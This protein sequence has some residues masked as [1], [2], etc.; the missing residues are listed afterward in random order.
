MTTFTTRLSAG[1]VIAAA[2]GAA[3]VARYST[4]QTAAADGWSA[5]NYDQSANRYSPLTQ[6][7]PANVSTLE[8]AWSVHLKP[9]GYA[10]KL[11]TDEAI[12]L[13][14]GNTMYSGSPYGAVIAVDATSG[15]EKWKFQLPNKD[16][17]AKRGIAYWPG[18][19]GHGASIVFGSNAGAL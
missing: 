8:R 3:G 11:I 7:G 15:A 19:S 10:G 4:G 16:I 12:P 17:P 2:I 9:A 5:S 13:V 1:L 6:I 18:A 14:I